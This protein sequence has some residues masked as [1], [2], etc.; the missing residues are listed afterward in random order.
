M[1]DKGASEAKQGF[2]NATNNA[3]TLQGRGADNWSG[4][5]PTLQKNATAPVGLTPQQEAEHNTATQQSVG[6]SNAG[7]AG[8]GALTAGRTGNPGSMISAIGSA[9]RGNARNLAQDALQT[10]EYSTNLAQQ[11]QQSALGELGKLYGTN[12]SGL[13]DMVRNQ[14]DAAKNVNAA[15]QSRFNDFMQVGKMVGGMGMMGAGMAGAGPGA[16]ASA[17]SAG[18]GMMG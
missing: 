1:F 9:S 16:G 7:I 10:K 14:N 5:Y 6:G 11:K 4:M 3:S 17:M 18:S 13:N 2:G 15:E 12:V 8:E